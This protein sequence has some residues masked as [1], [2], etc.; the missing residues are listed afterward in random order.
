MGDVQ[1]LEKSI[2]ELEKSI[3]SVDKVVLQNQREDLVLL[4]LQQGGLCVA[5]GEECCVYADYTGVIRQNKAALR[6]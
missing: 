1:I 3:S 6:K 2:I 4:F 5:L